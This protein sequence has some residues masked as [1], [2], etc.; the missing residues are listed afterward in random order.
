MNAMDFSNI[1][2]EFSRVWAEITFLPYEMK[3][4]GR[5]V[6]VD[7]G[8]RKPFNHVAHYRQE[9]EERL[10]A[11]YGSVVSNPGSYSRLEVY[12]KANK[13]SFSQ[14]VDDII[15]KIRT[16]EGLGFPENEHYQD[17]AEIRFFEQQE[18]WQQ[19]IPVVEVPTNIPV[20]KPQ[21]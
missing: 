5:Q 20:V 1:K 4:L 15:C 7:L 9:R 3:V 11:E 2:N 8:L 19:R 14:A 18:Y 17:P 10:Q 21:I 12:A 16:D 13:M 6:M